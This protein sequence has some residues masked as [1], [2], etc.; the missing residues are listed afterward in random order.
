MLHEDKAVALSTISAQKHFPDKTRGKTKAKNMYTASRRDAFMA[1]LP[2][3]A[4]VLREP[5]EE[6]SAKEPSKP[7]ARGRP[8]TQASRGVVRTASCPVLSFA[9]ADEALGE[10]K[11][12]FIDPDSTVVD[13]PR[14]DNREL[15]KGVNVAMRSI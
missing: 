11:D 2:R 8:L 14:L 15:V 4:T 5:E 3:V 7:A 6:Y 10:R 12:C 9:A 1:L 13:I